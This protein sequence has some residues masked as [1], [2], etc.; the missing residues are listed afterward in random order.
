MAKQPKKRAKRNMQDDLS[1][2]V[3]FCEQEKKTQ[4]KGRLTSVNRLVKAMSTL[5]A[6]SAEVS[7]N[8]RPFSSAKP[9]ASSVW[10]ERKCLKSDLLPTS[11]TMMFES[12]CSRTSLNHRETLS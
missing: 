5:V 2:W 7:M 1:M 4:D 10:M 8:I 12:A 6:S 9:L 3:V 11:M